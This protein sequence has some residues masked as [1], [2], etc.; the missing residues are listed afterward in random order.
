MQFLTNYV[1]GNLNQIDRSFLTGNRCPLT[2]RSRTLFLNVFVHSR[3]NLIPKFTFLF[4]GYFSAAKFHLF[5]C[6]PNQTVLSFEIKGAAFC[7]SI[8]PIGLTQYVPTDTFL[9]IPI[10]SAHSLL[11]LVLS[12]QLLPPPIDVDI[13]LYLHNSTSH[14]EQ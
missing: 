10:L 14:H 4:Y 13:A 5:I 12:S 2:T 3:R 7:T 8:R 1:G 9:V 6:F 11:P